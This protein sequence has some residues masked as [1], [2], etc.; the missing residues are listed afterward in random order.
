MGSVR[1]PFDSVYYNPM[2]MP[3]YI[4]LQVEPDDFRVTA[5]KNDGTIIDA[6]TVPA[7]S[8]QPAARKSKK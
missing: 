7:K 3:M 4:V 5:Y 2:D 6:V 1:R 8:P